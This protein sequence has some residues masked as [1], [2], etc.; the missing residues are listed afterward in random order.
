MPLTQDKPIPGV[1]AWGQTLRPELIMDYRTVLLEYFAYPKR[2]L[3][4]S[5]TARTGTAE[6]TALLSYVDL[7]T[8]D[9]T[10]DGVT[11]AK[12]LEYNG[13]ALDEYFS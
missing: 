3:L 10:A 12:T 1:Q 2:V 5:E 7:S 13:V 8:A 4:A 11:H 9:L 6:A